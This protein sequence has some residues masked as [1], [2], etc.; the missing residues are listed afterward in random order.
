MGKAQNY[1]QLVDA[2]L[3]GTGHGGLLVQ[4]SVCLNT[5]PPRS[6]RFWFPIKHLWNGGPGKLFAAEWIIDSRN[7][8][9]RAM[10]EEAKILVAPGFPKWPDY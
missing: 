1:L 5:I 9:L 6:V 10:G 7:K 3:E 2:K 4:L 8:D